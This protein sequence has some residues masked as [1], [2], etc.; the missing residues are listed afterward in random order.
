VSLPSEGFC[1]AVREAATR[2]TEQTGLAACLDVDAAAEAACGTG[3]LP[4]TVGVQLLRIVQEA[5][6]NVRKHAGEPSRVVLRLRAEDGLLRLTVAD[7]GAGFDPWIPPTPTKSGDEHYGLRV[8]RQRA[9]RVGG[10]LDVR[11]AP[12]RGTRVE[13]SVPLAVD[14]GAERVAAR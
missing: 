5:L 12:G 6:T 2:F 7:D 14:A 3:A 8:M 13:V 4:P 11:S 1:G 10:R 9:E